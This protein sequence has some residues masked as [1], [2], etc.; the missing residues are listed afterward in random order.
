MVGL[1]TKLR[2]NYCESRNTKTVSARTSNNIVKNI[3]VRL[4]TKFILGQFRLALWLLTLVSRFLL[5]FFII[6][7]LTSFG[8]PRM[9]GRAAA[10]HFFTFMNVIFCDDISTYLFNAEQISVNP[11]TFCSFGNEMF[12]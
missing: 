6:L 8:E 2:R 12:E 3:L 1:L 5:L 7:N 10:K 4:N 11:I 9:L